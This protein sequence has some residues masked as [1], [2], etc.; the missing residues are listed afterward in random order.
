[1]ASYKKYA[2]NLIGKWEDDIYGPQKNVT[3]DIYQTNWNKLTNDFNAVKDKLARNLEL[4]RNEY[5]NTLNNIQD[6]S[7]N[8]MQN[9]NID[10]AS[11]GLS[12][13]G[14]TNLVNQSDTQA[15]GEDIDK[16]LSS[17]L[18]TNLSNAEG[19]TQDVMKLGSE[20]S[21]LAGNLAEDM[22]KLT[23]ADA[24]N[25]QQYANLIAGIGNSAAGRAASR[26]SSGGGSG[27]SKKTKEEEET[28]EIKR[29]IRIAD[30]LASPD[31]TDDQKKEYLVRYL[32]VPAETAIAAVDG[33]NNNKTI[34][35]NN[36][37]LNNAQKSLRDIQNYRQARRDESSNSVLGKIVNDYNILSIPGALEYYAQNRV[38][39]LQNKND[40]LTYTDLYKLLYGNK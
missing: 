17:L 37:A 3:Q 9:A 22:G 36:I 26:A 10:L 7:F 2:E 11:R 20:Q 34:S 18:D 19:L 39:D 32:D 28:D 21:S 13:S 1:M 6:T 25:A 23:D 33:Y 35:N 8:R 29:R 16:A 12:G 30:T 15:K 4:A 38:N 31:F 5:T 40:N 27:S 14:I 24:A